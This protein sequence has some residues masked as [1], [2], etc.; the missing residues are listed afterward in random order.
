MGENKFLIVLRAGDTSIHKEW[1][2]PSTDKNFD[3]FI[4]YFGDKDN[5]FIEDSD[6]YM[7]SKG[8]KWPGTF[9]LIE[10]YKNIV[11]HYSA[12]WFPDEDLSTNATNISRMFNLFSDYNLMMAQPALTRDSYYSHNITLKREGTIL[13]YTNFVEVMAP[14]FSMEALKKCYSTFSKSV[15]GWGLD[16]IWP[17]ALGYPSDKIAIIDETPI[18]HTRPI[19]VNSWYKNLSMHP[20]KEMC[21]LAAENQVKFP[22][23]FKEYDSVLLDNTQ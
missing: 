3:L 2:E 22:Y 23:R 19:G 5:M 17:K 4:D 14:I 1:L 13:R 11:F 7:A 18:K 12:V 16:F 9:A 21:M 8:L 6:Y 20:F 10:G 15:S